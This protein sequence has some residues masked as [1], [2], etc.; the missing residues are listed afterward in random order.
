MRFSGIP[1]F[2]AAVRAVSNSVTHV[3]RAFAPEFFNWYSSSEALYA[4]LAGVWMP[5]KR[6]VAH[7]K[8]IVSIYRM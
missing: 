8:G 2:F 1:A 5:P 6:C 7:A 4:A 3:K